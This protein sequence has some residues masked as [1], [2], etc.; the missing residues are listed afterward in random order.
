MTNQT[1]NHTQEGQRNLSRTK[2]AKR[3]ILAG[4]LN[5]I[6]TLFIPFI[7]RT[8]LIK[9]IG[10]EYA[11]LNSLFISI[12]HVLNLAE[13]GFSNAMVYSMYEPIANK[14]DDAIC[15]LLNFYRKVYKIIGICVLGVGL[16]LIPFLP[17]LINGT[18]PDD[19]N[20]RVVYFAFLLNTSISYLLYGY[21]TS[22][23]NAYQRTDVISNIG[24]VTTLGLNLLQIVLLY[25]IPSYYIYVFLMPI[26]TIINNLI[27]SYVVD[28]MFPQYS[29]RG[30]IS[31]EQRTDIGKRVS[32]LAIQRVCYMV[33][34]NMA[35]IFLSMFLSLSVVAVYNN[36]NMIQSAFTG[37]LSIFTSS[38]LAGVGNSL[39]TQTK[40]ANLQSMKKFN[41][42]YMWI[43]GFAAIT[44]ACVFQPFMELWMGKEYML[45]L[46]SALLFGLY[47]FNTKL[48]DIYSIYF[49][50]AGLW[51]YGRW[52]FIFEV[53]LNVGLDLWFINLWGVNGILI[54]TII[55]H[56]IISLIYGTYLLFKFC[57]G[58]K[59]LLGFYGLQLFYLVISIIIFIL[60]YWACL[61]VESFIQVNNQFMTVFVRII[62]CAIIV[63]VLYFLFYH[64]TKEFSSS[65]KWLIAS[66]L[67]NK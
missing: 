7:V 44:L 25:V 1:N 35:S 62:V 4:F 12:L 5:K 24:S 47:F 18:P 38:I 67:K 60:S 34:N 33:R 43:S 23:L 3:G 63:N 19:I 41:F 61:K 32:G 59:P 53:V 52:M 45:P 65:T 48:G 2:N 66:V 16:V 58:C 26:F 27:V 50:A 14:N 51:W 39:Q 30:N 22:L 6:V 42:L 8:V 11:G 37:V 46:S 9:E 49:S 31:N 21:K 54:G 17:H 29:C 36:Y 15:A 13:L 40:D 20:I 64:R 10:I 57:F 55:A 56:F 28:R